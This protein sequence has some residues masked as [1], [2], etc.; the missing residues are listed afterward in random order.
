MKHLVIFDVDGT[1]VD[2]QNIILAAQARAF[3]AHNMPA[4][5]RTQALSVVGLSLIE[6]FTQLAGPDAPAAS[7][8]EAYKDAFHTLRS[9]P[10]MHE[11]FFGGAEETINALAQR[12]DV[13][14]AI[15]TGKS[16]RGV[17]YLVERAGWEHVFASVQTADTNASKP[18]PA[19]IHAAMAETGIDAAH[20]IMIGD[21][22]F[23]MI[24]ARAAGAH[25]QGVDWGYHPRSALIA[26]GAQHIADDFTALR[27]RLMHRL[28]NAVEAV[29]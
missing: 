15:A 25:A 4:L 21:T 11:P 14:L 8:A 23:D 9:D 17:A 1:L 5:E 2:S 20:T 16:R 13:M 10:A 18:S 22:S 3:A 12:D 26:G 28:G 27:G 6:S 24:M 19:M 29:S 7:L